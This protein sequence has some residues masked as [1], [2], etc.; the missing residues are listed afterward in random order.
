[1]TP[2]YELK[3]L[4][5]MNKSGFWLTRPTSGCDL[6]VLNAMNNSELWMT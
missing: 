2:G 6:M 1:M 4:D 5:A 3:S